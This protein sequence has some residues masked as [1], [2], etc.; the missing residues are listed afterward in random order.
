MNSDCN[1]FLLSRSSL[2][3]FESD[4][5]STNDEN[6]ES[7]K[8]NNVRLG[9]EAS[10]DASEG[11][12]VHDAENRPQRAIKVKIDL[13]FDYRD[14]GAQEW[15][16]DDV[17]E[18]DPSFLDFDDDSAFRSVAK[19]KK[20]GNGLSNG[21]RTSTNSFE[22]QLGVLFTIRKTL[23]NRAFDYACIFCNY[24]TEFKGYMKKHFSLHGNFLT[25]Q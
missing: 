14:D 15:D 3:S 18:E 17:E 22:K 12:G 10:K 4:R 21:L 16:E 7:K 8:S 23:D 6:D 19:R 24:R 11:S 13:D 2:I 9:T 25:V 1:R 20:P 5:H